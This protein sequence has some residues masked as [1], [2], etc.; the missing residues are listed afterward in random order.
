M[1]IALGSGKGGT[2]KTTVA[3]ALA[4]ALV[5]GAEDGRVLLADCD[6]EEPNAHLFLRPD[7]TASRPVES[8]VPEF[9][10][11]RCSF[12]GECA[13]FCRFHALSVAPG[14]L[15][16]FPELCH[17]CGG[18]FLACP[19]DG[20][21][22]RTTREIGVIESGRAGDLEFRHGRLRVGEPS[23]AAL[24]GRLRDS[25]PPTE[26]TILDA[27]P[28]TACTFV[29][30]V[31]GADFCLLVGEP[32]PFGVHDLEAAVEVTE[33]LGVPRG[34]VINKSAAESG[35]GD[36]ELE[37]MAARR[38]VDILLRIPHDRAVAEAAT[39]G[40]GLLEVRPELAAE[41]RDLAGEIA[42]RARREAS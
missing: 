25:L 28:G 8:E 11:T 4:R 14:S 40:G 2:G 41:L 23:A 15:Q 18:C 19:R 33:L 37:R 12:C 10:A 16:V 27:P 13:R 35:D 39:R 6:V 30:T 32:T 42:G 24:V 22:V 38:G 7:I 1:I 36:A 31:H 29:E 34:I 26:W 5:P 3:V 21:L 9:D 20:A 17:S